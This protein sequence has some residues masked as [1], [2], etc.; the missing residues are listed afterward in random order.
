MIQTQIETPILPHPGYP[1]KI[2]LN[3][4]VYSAN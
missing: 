4:V 3:K 1:G 2:H